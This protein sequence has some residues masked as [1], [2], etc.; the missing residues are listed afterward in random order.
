MWEPSTCGAFELAVARDG[1]GRLIATLRSRRSHQVI[2]T[3][4]S[5]GPSYHV[6]TNPALKASV[7]AAL[8]P[9]WGALKHRDW[10][11]NV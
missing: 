6:S 10:G 8:S 1:R 7:E 4:T 3:C 9:Y 5:D 2:A 11:A